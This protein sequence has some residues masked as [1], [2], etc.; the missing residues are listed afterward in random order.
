MDFSATDVFFSDTLKSLQYFCAKHSGGDGNCIGALGNAMNDAFDRGQSVW[1]ST[2]R[3]HLGD[4]TTTTTASGSREPSVSQE[5]PPLLVPINTTPATTLP[6]CVRIHGISENAKGAGAFWR[7]SEWLA[8]G[9]RRHPRIHVVH[10]DNLKGYPLRNDHTYKEESGAAK[11]TTCNTTPAVD[12]SEEGEGSAHGAVDW[13]IYLW[14]STSPVRR[15]ND[16]ATNFI[17]SH[18]DRKVLSVRSHP[19]LAPELVSV[20]RSKL[21]V[22]DLQVCMTC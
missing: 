3:D 11:P 14:M 6:P 4:A 18:D 20:D 7:A 22:I 13:Y 5:A 2:S 9:L 10:G 12:A 19:R 21:V 16:N 1:N 8:E 17:L 15:R